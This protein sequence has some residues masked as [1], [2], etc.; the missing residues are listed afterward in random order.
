MLRLSEASAAAA[1]RL[2]SWKQPTAGMTVV[3]AGALFL[4]YA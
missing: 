1:V 4:I 2:P 3:A